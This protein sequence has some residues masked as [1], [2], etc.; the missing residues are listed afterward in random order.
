MATRED[1]HLQTAGV[2]ETA[3]EEENLWLSRTEATDQMKYIITDPFLKL[4]IQ[5]SLSG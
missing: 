5:Y 1:G 2:G 4:P 3:A